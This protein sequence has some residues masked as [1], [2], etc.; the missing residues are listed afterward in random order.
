MSRGGH[1]WGL[2][3]FP[4]AWVPVALASVGVLSGSGLALRVRGGCTRAL[5]SLGLVTGGGG[6]LA[7]E[8]PRANLFAPGALRESVGGWPLA[9]VSTK[10]L[11]ASPKPVPDSLGGRDPV[12]GRL[13]LRGACRGT[14]RSL[15]FGQG[16]SGGSWRTI[17]LGNS[18][19]ANG[20]P[21]AFLPAVG[22]RSKT[23]GMRTGVWAV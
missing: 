15:T 10:T 5:G 22:L 12:A 6:S 16:Q 4:A 8:V 20:S 13:H 14:V 11:G 19:G 9:I 17:F 2:A 23:G 1:C 18:V 21:W 3:C 7:P